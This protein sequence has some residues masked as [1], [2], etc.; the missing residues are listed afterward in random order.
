[1]VYIVGQ[2]S[3]NNPACVDICPPIT[4]VEEKQSQRERTFDFSCLLFYVQGRKQTRFAELVDMDIKSWSQMLFRK[5]QEKVSKIRTNEY[6]L[7]SVEFSR[8]II[9]ITIIIRLY[10]RRVNT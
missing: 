4:F 1:M 6:K 9:I 10:L 7:N 5:V 8:F 3:R 2:L